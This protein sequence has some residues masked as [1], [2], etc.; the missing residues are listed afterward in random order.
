M[1]EKSGAGVGGLQATVSEMREAPHFAQ[2]RAPGRLS[3]PQLGQ[4][5][6]HLLSE[7]GGQ[8]ATFCSRQ[9]YCIAKVVKTQ[10]GSMGCRT[11][12]ARWL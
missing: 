11:L 3:A 5:I 4:I 2:K 1:A 10:I 9:P 12:P 8:M 7:M 6:V